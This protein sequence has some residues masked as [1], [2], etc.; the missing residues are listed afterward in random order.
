MLARCGR[1]GATVEV[2]GEGRFQCPS[3]GTTN[4]VS[5]PPEATPSPPDVAPI[6]K[7]EQPAER[8]R[9]PAC[10]FEFIV[11]EVTAAICPNCREEVAVEQ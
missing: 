5:A 11:G 1:C 2:S 7:P 9:C 4:Q 3:C 10:S 8:L 6:P